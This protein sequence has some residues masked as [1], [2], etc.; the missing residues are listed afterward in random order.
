M[1]LEGLQSILGICHQ[2]RNV[3]PHLS[4]TYKQQRTTLFAAMLSAIAAA[5]PSSKATV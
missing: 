4:K 2:G 5:A 3:M 1:E